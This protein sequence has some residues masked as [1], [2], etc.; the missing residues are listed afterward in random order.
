MATWKLVKNLFYHA[1]D[2][3]FERVS[4][5]SENTIQTKVSLYELGLSNSNINSYLSFRETYGYLCTD[6]SVNT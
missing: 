5:D 4:K 1:V 3:L 6:M 2:R